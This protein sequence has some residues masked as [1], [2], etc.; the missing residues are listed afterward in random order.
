[1][2]KK[3]LG[4]TGLEVSIVG[5]GGGN[6]GLRNPDG[7]YQQHILNPSVNL[8]DTELGI[9]TV[10]AALETGATLV[11]TAPKYE[12]GGSEQIIGK[13]FSRRPDLLGQC[14]V[15]TKIG[16]TYPNDGFDHSYARAMRSFEES[17]ARLG[18]DHFQLLYLHDPMG[19]DMDFV[20]G[21]KGTMQAL[22]DLRSAGKV[23]WIGVAANDPDTS[24]DYIETG[25]FDVATVSGAWSLI[26]QKAGSRILPATLHHN[27]G[28]V[29]TTAI[30]RGL[31]VTGPMEG[32]R[33]IERNFSRQCLAR[34]AQIKK[35]CD[36]FRI[37]LVAVALQWC[38]RHPQVT[39]VIPGARIPEEARENTLAGSVVVIPE[40]FWDALKPL[41]SNFES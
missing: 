25:E 28:I 17:A 34:V 3:I 11:D 20:M 1:M 40:E 35:L 2:R 4:R 6:L 7:P 26:N 19:F 27:V 14:L 23:K 37:P 16:C 24:A 22:R 10:Y 32:M 31:L 9:A 12:A 38:T 39:S 21:S 30:E 18:R 41:V 15:P 8:A 33:Y 29:V 13:A 36:Q 5:L